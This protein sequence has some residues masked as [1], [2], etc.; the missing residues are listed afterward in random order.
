MSKNIE[1]ITKLQDSDG[2]WYW[3]PNSLKEVF[4]FI[5]GKLSGLEYMENPDL[6]DFFEDAFGHYRTGGDMDNKPRYFEQ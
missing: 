4:E 5:I 6:F 1:D 3:I 2:D